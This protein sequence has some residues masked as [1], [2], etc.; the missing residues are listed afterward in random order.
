MS[1]HGKIRCE[2][3]ANARSDACQVQHHTAR[4]DGRAGR[5]LCPPLAEARIVLCLSRLVIH[6]V[7]ANRFVRRI[8]S[9]EILYSLS[10][11]FHGRR[12]EMGL[13]SSDNAMPVMD[14]VWRS[15]PAACSSSIYLR[16]T[17]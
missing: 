11:L 10:M 3:L 8:K 16:R 5:L 6:A 7:L 4:L 9:F 13:L 2:W 15:R 17:G 14:E 12:S 1:G